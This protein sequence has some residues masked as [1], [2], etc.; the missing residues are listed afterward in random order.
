MDAL[1]DKAHG[2]GGIVCKGVHLALQGLTVGFHGAGVPSALLRS[3]FQCV[4]KQVITDSKLLHLV[5]CEA[6]V[7]GQNA[8][9]VDAGIR[10]LPHVHGGC[11]AYIGNLL[12]V[13]R[14]ALELD[15]SAA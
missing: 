6:G 11:L 1:G 15:I 13:G 7:V 3:S 10:K 8:V 2:L 9:D 12:Q 14:H 4:G 5:F